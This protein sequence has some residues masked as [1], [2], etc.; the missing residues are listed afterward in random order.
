[1]ADE[2]KDDGFEVYAKMSR[3]HALIDWTIICLMRLEK[4]KTSLRNMKVDCHNE[5][6]TKH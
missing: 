5:R 4:Q 1:M 3:W 2:K 6:A